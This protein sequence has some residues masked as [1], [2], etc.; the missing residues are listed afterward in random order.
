[1]GGVKK[2]RGMPDDGGLQRDQQQTMAVLE[3]DLAYTAGHPETVA[4]L[5]LVRRLQA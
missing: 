2:G 5:A 1:M 3:G 4:L